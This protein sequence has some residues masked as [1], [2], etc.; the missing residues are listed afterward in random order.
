ML[1][2]VQRRFNNSDVTAQGSFAGVPHFS[3]LKFLYERNMHSGIVSAHQIPTHLRESFAVRTFLEVKNPTQP[4]FARCYSAIAS[5]FAG[6]LAP[7]KSTT[8]RR[9]KKLHYICDTIINIS[10]GKYLEKPLFY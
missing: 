4:I 10:P 2:K 8:L 5:G 6:F 1:K 9:E 7:F 3:E